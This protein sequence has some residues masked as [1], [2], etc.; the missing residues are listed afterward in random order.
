MI[1]SG[2]Q[3]ALLGKHPTFGV[4]PPSP[5]Q[6]VDVG[7][8]VPFFVLHK[9]HERPQTG[10]NEGMAAYPREKPLQTGPAGLDLE[11]AEPVG[12]QKDLARKWRDYH[13][14]R[15]VLENTAER[16]KVGVAPPD[17]AAAFFERGNVGLG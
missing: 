16:H 3:E 2:V 6:L 12:G 5:A 14:R 1:I 13:P 8:G 15:F 11:V 17:P 7:P 10:L 9:L 4:S